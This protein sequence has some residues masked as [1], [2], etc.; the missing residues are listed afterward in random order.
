MVTR[1]SACEGSLL[2]QALSASTSKD[3][4]IAARWPSGQGKIGAGGALFAGASGT[5]SQFLLSGIDRHLLD[6]IIRQ[7][8]LVEDLLVAAI[9]DELAERPSD[10]LLQLRCVL[11]D[12]DAGELARDTLADRRVAVGLERN[13]IG[14]G[15]VALHGGIDPALLQLGA[16]IGRALG[17]D[18]ADERLSGSLALQFAPGGD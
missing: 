16:G 10:R 9:R 6:R 1:R 7:F 13:H 15:L 11:G 18:H 3:R 17:A 12:A 2:V 8:P 5:L 4:N 14:Q